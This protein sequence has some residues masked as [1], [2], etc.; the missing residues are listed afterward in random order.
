MAAFILFLLLSCFLSLIMAAWPASILVTVIVWGAVLILAGLYLKRIQLLGLYLT[1]MAVLFWFGGLI[2]A[3]AVLAVGGL[4]IMI[5][6]YMAWRGGQYYELQKAGI[7]VAV[8]GLSLFLGIVSVQ[9]GDTWKQELQTGMDNYIKQS[10]QSY[11]ESGLDK[12]YA[13][14][15]MTREVF[16]EKAKEASQIILRHMWAICY[17]QV[18]ITVFFA[19]LLA[20]I[21]SRKS[22]DERLKKKPYSQ[23]IMAWQL[24][25]VVIAGMVLCLWGNK[26]SSALLLVGSNILVILV[27]ITVY[28]GLAAVIFKIRQMRPTARRWFIIV[29]VVLST[30]FLPSALIFFSIFGM[31]D[32]LLDYRKLRIKKGDLA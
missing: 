7:A 31:F 22:T 10:V 24:V 29:L 6:S 27:P 26:L 19:L 30:V 18:I 15:G 3:L 16:I 14:Q 20:S 2:G 21:I 13:E 1:N 23:E 17:L 4:A 28:Y 11:D 9:F 25:W 12:L 8:V 5:M 32:A